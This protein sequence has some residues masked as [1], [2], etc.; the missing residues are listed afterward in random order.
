[1]FLTLKMV[2]ID[3]FEWALRVD[4]EM[5]LTVTLMGILTPPIHGYLFLH[6]GQ[7][8]YILYF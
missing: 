2:E 5:L 4:W 7:T 1:M 3:M 8:T 6:K